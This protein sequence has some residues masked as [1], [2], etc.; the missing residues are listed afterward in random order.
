MS[1]SS[2]AS[3]TDTL[4]LHHHAVLL[5]TFF[6]SSVQLSRSK[7]LCAYCISS[8]IPTPGILTNSIAVV[9]DLVFFSFFPPPGP[10][11]LCRPSCSCN[12]GVTNLYG[13]GRCGEL[14][15]PNARVLLRTSDSWRSRA[16][17]PHRI[18]IG[19]NSPVPSMY[20]RL[21]RQCVCLSSWGGS[22]V[23]QTS[24]DSVDG[25]RLWLI[26]K[27]AGKVVDPKKERGRP[28]GGKCSSTFLSTL[29][30]IISIH[31]PYPRITLGRYQPRGN[32]SQRAEWE[33]V[34]PSSLV[35]CKTCSSSSSLI[36]FSVPSSQW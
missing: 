36:S 18:P 29:P 32:S 21:Q 22:T 11:H 23:D 17:R 13:L 16:C 20:P 4:L 10:V 27:A 3:F 12:T 26:I 15:D 1:L 25:G 6:S 19:A 31:H 2:A 7:S 34:I 8:H 30:S 24:R 33:D 14:V 35:S 5:Q 28:S 9:S